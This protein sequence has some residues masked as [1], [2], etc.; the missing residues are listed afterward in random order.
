MIEKQLSTHQIFTE[1]QG[2]EV[3]IVPVSAKSSEG[4]NDLLETIDLQ[5]E[6]MDT[7][8]ADPLPYGEA[9]VLESLFDRGAGY[10][11][12]VIV[13]WGSLKVKP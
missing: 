3:L 9:I 7:L 6:M 8:H 13:K 2:G 10:S 12:D 11:A 1:K 4:I 5:A